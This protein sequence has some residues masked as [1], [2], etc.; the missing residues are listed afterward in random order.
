MPSYL[1]KKR[2]NIGLKEE[3]NKNYWWFTQLHGWEPYKWAM[4]SQVVFIYKTNNPHNSFIM[5]PFYIYPHSLNF[6]TLEVNDRLILI[7]EMEYPYL[8]F[9]I[10]VQN[11]G[12]T[13]ICVRNKI[14]FHRYHLPWHWS[15]NVKQIHPKSRS[16]R[17]YTFTS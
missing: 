7:K 5:S 3:I 14:N 15:R 8:I 12:S 11:N 17:E 13:G 6:L 9:F 1:K 10:I 4:E 2:K 16:S